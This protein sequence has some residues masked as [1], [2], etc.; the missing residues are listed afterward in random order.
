MKQQKV[1]VSG[2]RSHNDLPKKKDD[3]W[4]RLLF[5]AFSIFLRPCGSKRPF[6]SSE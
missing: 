6:G 2:G 5:D 1:S 3:E 4:N